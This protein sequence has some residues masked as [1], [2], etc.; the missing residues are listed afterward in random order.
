M[1]LN[2]ATVAGP[3]GV[4]ELWAAGTAVADAAGHVFG[5]D[6][7]R[8]N[9]A[10]MR[11][12]PVAVCFRGDPRRLRAEAA[13][14]ARVTHAHP[15]GVDA[16]VVQAAAIGAALCDEDILAAARPAARTE[17]MRAGLQAV[18]E[19]LASR[20]AASGR[21]ARAAGK[22][23]RRPGVGLRRGLRGACAPNV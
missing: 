14:S 16:A 6:G 19:L 12:A 7:S 1:S 22:L 18:G 17:E 23:V 11:I 20:A 15:V 21:R 9:G 5:G 4:F 2:V 10:A 13:A 3:S 8:G